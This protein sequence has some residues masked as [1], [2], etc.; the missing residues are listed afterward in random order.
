[1]KKLVYLIFVFFCLKINTKLYYLNNAGINNQYNCKLDGSLFQ[2]LNYILT[3]CEPDDQIME[4]IV[5]DNNFSFENVT[6]D[7]FDKVKV[8][9][10]KSTNEQKKVIFINSFTIHNCEIHLNYFIIKPTRE[11]NQVFKIDIPSFYFINSNV[12]MTYLDFID[13]KPQIILVDT[14]LNMEDV[15]F[16]D[17][18]EDNMT[19][20]KNNIPIIHSSS[21]MLPPINVIKL[22][23]IKLIEMKFP[24]LI[25]CSNNLVINN[26]EIKSHSVSNS[27]QNLQSNIGIYGVFT[28][29][30]TKNIEFKSV[31]VTLSNFDIP[32]IV[33]N[34][35]SNEHTTVNI[36]SLEI[37]ETTFSN[38]PKSNVG[39]IVGIFNGKF[40]IILKVFFSVFFI[41]L[42]Y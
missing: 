4:I 41:I 42:E 6:F 31:T 10:I 33:S 23:N 34:S 14:D 19:E 1:M 37:S 32:L 20:K 29:F 28:F 8:L 24:F 5:D 11:T 17:I 13:V 25:S 16:S 3:F 30:C 39:N 15:N 26:I 7:C 9:T 2:T 35:N 12:T 22:N 38:S 18:N 36:N 27:Y 40:N 21:S